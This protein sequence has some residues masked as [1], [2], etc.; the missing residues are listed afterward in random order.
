MMSSE[1]LLLGS[2]AVIFAVPLGYLIS[3]TTPGAYRYHL[4]LL[5]YVL[6]I[7]LMFF[8]ALAATLYHTTKA[9]S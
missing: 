1:F 8:T 3:V 7:G 9:V 2:V 5:D 6:G 4:Q